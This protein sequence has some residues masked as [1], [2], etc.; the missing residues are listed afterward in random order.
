MGEKSH[1]ESRENLLGKD[2]SPEL[3][4]LLSNEK[5]VTKDTPPCFIWATG[6]DKTVPIEN[7]MDFARALRKAGVPFDF[8]IYQKGSHGGPVEAAKAKSGTSSN[9]L[10]PWAT[11]LLFWLRQNGWLQ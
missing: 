9:Y 3:I 1:G 11:D 4:D 8:H 7:S 10:H 5:H 6:E 2:P